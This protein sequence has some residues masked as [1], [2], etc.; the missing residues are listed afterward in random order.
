M[1]ASDLVVSGFLSR[2]GNA[3]GS[4]V[5]LGD[6][7]SAHSGYTAGPRPCRC[8]GCLEIAVMELH[9]CRKQ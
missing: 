7:R 8:E 4:I 9:E 6:G 2:S 5:Q 1:T 3:M